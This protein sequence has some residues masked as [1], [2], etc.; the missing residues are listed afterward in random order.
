ASIPRADDPSVPI[1]PIP[2]TLPSL[3]DP[4]AQCRFYSRCERRQPECL[5]EIAMQ[6][7]AGGRGARC[8]FA[9]A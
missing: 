9:G 5:A 6:P 2:G 1:R 7:L 4:P 3:I 8:L